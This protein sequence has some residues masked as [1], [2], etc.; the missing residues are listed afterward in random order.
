MSRYILYTC[1]YVKY[2]S[3]YIFVY[4]ALSHNIFSFCHC[5]VLHILVC[6]CV[7]VCLF[8]CVCVC[9]LGFKEEK[10]Y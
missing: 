6:V 4:K 8:V 1:I 5:N 9:I 10:E 7:C 2:F 3:I